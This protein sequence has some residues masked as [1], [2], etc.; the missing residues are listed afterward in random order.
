[1]SHL[2][3]AADAGDVDPSDADDVPVAELLPELYREVLDFVAALEL[4]HHRVDASRV[5]AE[6][7][8]AYSGPWNPAALGKLR[9]LRAHAERVIAGRE[10]ARRSPPNAFEIAISRLTLVRPA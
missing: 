8:F 1:M 7:T 6:A 10:R 4:R 3:A 2:A 9:A 5:R